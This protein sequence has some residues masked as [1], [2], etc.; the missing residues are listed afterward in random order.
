MLVCE[1]DFR[2]TTKHTEID[3]PNL[4]VAKLMLSLKSRRYVRE[5]F[6][7][8][9]M[10]YFLTNEGI[11]FLREYLHLPADVVPATMKRKPGSNDGPL[12]LCSFY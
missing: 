5:Q 9:H 8:N 7:W 6:N 11:E 10:Y 3:V 4:Y 2:P 1:K 12:P